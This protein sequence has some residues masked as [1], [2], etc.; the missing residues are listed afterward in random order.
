MRNA[1]GAVVLAL[2][3]AVLWKIWPREAIAA[4]A[5]ERGSGTARTLEPAAAPR[6]P[7]ANALRVLFV[8][9]S[10]TY[11]HDMPRMVAALADAD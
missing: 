11:M 1:L 10:H 4:Y 8:G 6:V 7:A 5:L 3:V 9:N 2:L